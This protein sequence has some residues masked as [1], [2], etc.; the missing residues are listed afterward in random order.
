MSHQAKT[1]VAPEDYLALERQAEYKSEYFD[2]EIF[3]MTGAS[4]EHNLITLNV[5]SELRAQLKKRD[6]KTYSNDMR[7]K[8]P[9]SGLYTYPDVAVVCGAAQ[10]EDDAVDTLLN[11]VLIAE[12][13][14]KS[15]ARYDRA[16]KFSDYRSIPSF[17]E[18]LLVAQDE[19]RVEH[20]VRQ[21]DGRWLLTEYRSLEDVVQLD[22]IQCLLSLKEI[23]DKVSLTQP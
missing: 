20:N 2:G 15:T 18:Y 6:C 13:L 22:S 14:S 21:A 8:V 23:Y 17:A 5:A 16:G 10:F 11:P 12:V 4:E 3:A 9:A 19:Y 1:Y 7:V